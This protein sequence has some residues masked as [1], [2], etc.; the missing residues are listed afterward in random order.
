M[1]QFT[2]KVTIDEYAKVLD[3]ELKPGGRYF[4]TV[5]ATHINFVPIMAC[6]IK[7]CAKGY[8]LLLDKV[9][10]L[11]EVPSEFSMKSLVIKL[12]NEPVEEEEEEPGLPY[13]KLWVDG[14]DAD[15]A[16]CMEKIK[17]MNRLLEGDVVISGYI[18]SATC[19][20]TFFPATV[21]VQIFHAER[22]LT[23]AAVGYIEK[24][25]VEGGEVNIERKTFGT[26]M[27]FTADPDPDEVIGAPPKVFSVFLQNIGSNVLTLTI[28]EET[29][30]PEEGKPYKLF[31]IQKP[32]STGKTKT[33]SFTLDPTVIMA[34]EY[35]AGLGGAP[36]KKKRGSVAKN[37]KP[38]PK[39]EEPKPAEE[40]KPRTSFIGSIKRGFSLT[41]GKEV[42]K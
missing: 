42:K 31:V 33:I 37:V 10:G 1:V 26:E 40:P 2:W 14:S 5:L 15:L 20:P 22:S 12:K 36:E 27:T 3:T 29:V 9:D 4:M 8:D 21:G 17:S 30:V 7:C 28:E 41:K 38:A 25:P 11:E 6:G 19:E 24:I 13:H 16:A 34:A 18:D 39:K 23:T 32:G 35:V